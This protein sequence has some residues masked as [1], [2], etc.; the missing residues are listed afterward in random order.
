MAYPEFMLGRLIALGKQ[1]GVHLVGVGESWWRLFAKIV[2][3]VAGT[4]ATMACWDEQL[5]AGLKV[6]IDGA[7]HRV[8]ALWDE[9]STTE[10]WGFLLVDTKNAFN[11]INQVEMLWTVRHLCPSGYF[12]S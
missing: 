5:C 7:I 4:E 11:K 3:K 2:L 9:N 12:L 8:Q 1:P 6:R 10:D